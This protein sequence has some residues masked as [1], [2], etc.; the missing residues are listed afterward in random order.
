MKVVGLTGG[1]GSGKSTVAGTLE[2]LGAYVIDADKLAREVV[3]VGTEGLAAVRARFGE[4]VMAADGASLDRRALGRVVFED[5]AARRDLEGIL[6][7]RI[8]ALFAERV[9]A[10]RMSGAPLVVYDVP[11]LFE[12]DSASMFD[13]VV[14][15]WARQETRRARIA[16]RDELSEA[17]IKARMASQIP[18]E[19]KVQ[20]ADHVID[21]DG[22]QEATLAAVEALF[23]KL[24]ATALP[25]SEPAND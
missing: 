24:T 2:R 19:Q 13:T 14:V 7:P 20:Q 11:L 17:E 22:S 12:R 21:N 25:E 4:T 8:S 16:A 9:Q 15:V 5:A 6:H 18:L 10:A 23:K 1:I 3:D